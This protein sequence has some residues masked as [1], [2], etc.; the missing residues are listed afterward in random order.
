MAFEVTDASW[1]KP[2][3]LAAVNR[4]RSK[5]V[6]CYYVTVLHSHHVHCAHNIT[7]LVQ[8]INGLYSVS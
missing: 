4:L 1:E 3:F 8:F 5:H 7:F 6:D 2:G